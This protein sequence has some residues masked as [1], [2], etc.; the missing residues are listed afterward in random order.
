M[1]VRF[2]RKHVAWYMLA[3]DQEKKFRSVFNALESSTDQL[4]ALELYFDNLN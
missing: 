4:D 3:Y 2:A 1:G